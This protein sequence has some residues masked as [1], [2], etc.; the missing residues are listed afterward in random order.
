MY[1]LVV[2]YQLGCIVEING[3]HNKKRCHHTQFDQTR[4]KNHSSDNTF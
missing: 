2:T 4:R 3:D 1:Y